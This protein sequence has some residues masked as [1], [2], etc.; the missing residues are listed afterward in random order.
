MGGRKDLDELLQGVAG[1]L[2]VLQLGGQLTGL[3]LQPRDS[4]RARLPRP[5]QL[6][7]LLLQRRPGVPLLPQVLVSLRQ[8][9]AFNDRTDSRST[10][11]GM[12][13]RQTSGCPCCEH[14]Y[15]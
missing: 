4:L 10:S 15:T 6:R 14:A 9:H 13:R 8:H 1:G 11:L 2:A 7:Q 5:L 12:I 3:R